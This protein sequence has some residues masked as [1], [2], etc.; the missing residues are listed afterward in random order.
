VKYIEWNRDKNESLKEERDIS[1]EEISEA[2]TSKK[3]LDAFD[4]PNQKKY[5]KQ[6]VFVVEIRD[7]AYFVAY[8]EDDKKIFLKTIY[9]DHQL[10][11][12]Y[13]RK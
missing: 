5:P 10:T 4:H 7:Y 8:V 2:I 12:K 13:L 11:K 1:F 6:R 3:I 9:P